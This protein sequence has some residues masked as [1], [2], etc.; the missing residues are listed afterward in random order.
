MRSPCCLFSCVKVKRKIVPVL[1]KLSTTPRRCMVSECIDPRFLDLGTSWRGVVSFTPR[2]P[3][4][5]EVAPCTDWVDPGASLDDVGMRTILTL[6][7]LE[8][9]KLSRP[10]R[11]QSPY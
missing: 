2:P 11:S 3:N 10:A 7:G 6:P 8:L 9:R 5:G 4:P 1:K